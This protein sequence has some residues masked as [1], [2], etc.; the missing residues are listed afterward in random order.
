MMSID[1]PFRVNRN[2][3]DKPLVVGNETFEHGLGVHSRTLLRYELAG[4]YREFVT[5]LGLDRSAGPY[6]AV[7]VSV[8]VDGVTQF[9]ES[10]AYPSELRG[11]VRISVEGSRT[12]ELLVDFGPNGSMQDRFNWIE[13][14]LVRR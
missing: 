8:R 12:L 6:A 13:P 10:I 5:R 14:G 1:W 7:D 4:G 9:S 3:L 2:V 11:P